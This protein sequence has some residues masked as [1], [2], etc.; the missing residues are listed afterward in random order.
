MGAKAKSHH[1]YNGGNGGGGGGSESSS[2]TSPS[3][4][5]SPRRNSSSISHYRRKLRSKPMSV[6]AGFLVLRRFLRLLVVLPLLYVS[7]LVM[8]VGVGPFCALVS[9]TPH[10]GSVYRS[11]EM[12]RQLWPH[13]Q[14][15]NSTP[16][17]VLPFF[18]SLVVLFIL[19]VWIL[20][21]CMKRK[22][23]KIFEVQIFN[24]EGWKMK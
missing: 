18:F 6:V 10:P 2:S 23:S 14:A 16:I 19:C 5:P 4:P 15:D 8:C 17:E 12:F 13:I 11:H 1:H 3:P 22:T 21:K 24:L 7:G 9:H 20:G